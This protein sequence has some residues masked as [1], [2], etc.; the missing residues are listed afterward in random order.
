M[1]ATIQAVQPSSAW[2][3]VVIGSVAVLAAGI[4]VAAG[5]F[6]LTS[7][8]GAGLGAGAGYVP[9]DAAYYFEISVEPSA[10]QD[11][12]LRELLGRFPPIEGVDLDRPLHEQLVEVLEENVARSDGD[13][14]YADDVA[15]WFGGTI[16]VAIPDMD[17]ASF[18]DPMS[19]PEPPEWLF[20]A[21]VADA[22][23]ARAT[24]D[25]LL[26][27]AADEGHEVTE[28]THRGTVVW[29]IVREPAFSGEPGAVA[30]TDDALLVA[31][32]G[33]DVRRALDLAADGGSLATD[34]GWTSLT[35]QL[36][37]D[38]LLFGVFDVTEL[39]E[40]S[41]SSSLGMSGLD[42]DAFEAL[43]E[44]QSLRGAFAISA[45]GDL[46]AFDSAAD[47]PTGRLA[48]ANAD[49]GLA[50]EV[51][52]DA[53]YFADG[54]NLGAS[55]TAFV[56]A[57]KETMASDPFA[58]DQ[59]E[60]MESA[61]GAELEDFVSW[62]GDGAMVAGWDGS[63]PYA[64]FVIV[65]TDVEAARDRLE[66]L[67]GFARLGNMDPSMGLTVEDGEV[68][69]VTVTTI[70]WANAMTDPLMGAPTGFAVE[71]AVTD[72]RAIIGLGDRFVDRALE[73]DPADS[74]AADDRFSGPVDTFGGPN[75]TGVTWLD[76]RG[77]RVALEESFLP[78]A[79]SF[80]MTGYDEVVAWLEPLD[81][82][83]FVSR[84][85]GDIVVQRGGLL[86]D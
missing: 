36:P 33:D 69:G 11:A 52:A 64:G 60:T 3:A 72:D 6:L 2:R 49:R 43:F 23:A 21:S 74:L 27:L 37:D 32:D 55:F 85:Q 80:G 28:M 31:E 25:R 44:G 42:T 47:A 5:S 62:M 59:I 75:N 38:R 29:E 57:M 17:V 58:G 86:V 15:P 4:G 30:I 54:G 22:E 84:I 73:L 50:D 12:A 24:A 78:M 66:Q 35:R 41:F 14:S 1:S 34:A 48:V 51:P 76:L 70:R 45:A 77:L 13:F 81:R 65:P 8:G 19:A 83:V 46:L 39:I 20:I 26:D 63:E 56:E 79:E 53:I 18:A 71:F 82:I 67:A 16:A 9:A 40:A 7:R 68:A 10:A 61:I